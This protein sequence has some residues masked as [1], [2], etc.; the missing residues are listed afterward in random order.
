MRYAPYAVCTY[1]MRTVCYAQQ[2]DQIKINLSIYSAPFP[3]LDV[4]LFRY[5]APSFIAGDTFQK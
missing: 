1:A 5:S 2:Q 4:D 3:Q